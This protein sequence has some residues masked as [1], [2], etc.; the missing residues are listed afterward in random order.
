MDEDWGNESIVPAVTTASVA[1]E[2]PEIKLFGK[3]DSNEVQ[4]ADMSLQVC[5]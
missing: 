4:I 1:S 2:L 5:I 3:W